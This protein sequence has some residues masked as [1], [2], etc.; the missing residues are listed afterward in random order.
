MISPYSLDDVLAL[1]EVERLDPDGRVRVKHAYLDTYAAYE[2]RVPYRQ[3][4]L[5][6][7][8]GVALYELNKSV[9]AYSSAVREAQRLGKVVRS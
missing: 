8:E 2:A 6:G 3:R 1:P 5:P 9:A 7:V 4:D